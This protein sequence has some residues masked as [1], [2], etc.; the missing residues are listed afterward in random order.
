MITT[1]YQFPKQLFVCLVFILMS[2]VPLSAQNCEVVAHIVEQGSEGE[3]HS[4]VLFPAGTSTRYTTLADVEGERGFFYGDKYYITVSN[5]NETEMVFRYYNVSSWTLAATQA[6][7]NDGR[8]L[9]SAVYNP[10]DSMVYCVAQDLETRAYVWYKEQVQD[11]VMTVVVGSE[12]DLSR[13]YYAL[14]ATSDGVIYGFAAD[15]GLYQ[16]DPQ[17]GSGERLLGTGSVGKEQQ[18]SWLDESAGVLYRAVPSSIGTTFYNYNLTEKSEKFGKVYSSIKSVVALAVNDFPVE[19]SKPKAVSNLGVQWGD[20]HN[21][22][23]IVFTAP[24][25]DVNGNEMVDTLTATVWIDGLTVDTLQVLPGEECRMPYEFTDGSH[26]LSVVVGNAY[27]ESQVATCQVYAGFD[28]PQS[29]RRVNIACD[30]PCVDIWWATPQGEHGQA[31]DE[32]NLRYRVV[33]YP[34]CVLVADTPATALCDTLPLMPFMYQYGVLAYLPDYETTE[35]TSSPFYYNCI[36]Q[37]PFEFTSWNDFVFQSFVVDDTNEDGTS[38]SCFTTASGATSVRYMYSTIHD[39]DDYLYFPTM[40]LQEGIYYEATVYLRAG[41]EKY[42]EVFSMGVMSEDENGSRVELF[43][44]EVVESKA[45]RR[46]SKGFVVD[47]SG[48]YRLYIHCTSPANHYILYVDSVSVTTQGVGTQPQSVSD[49]MLQPDA[50]HPSIVTIQSVAPTM[51][52]AGTILDRLDEISLYRN[53]QLL[54]TWQNPLP[55]ETITYRDSVS[56]IDNYNYRLVATNEAGNSQPAEQSIVR[57]VADYPFAHDFMQGVGFF[58][59]IDHNHDGTTWHFYDDRFMG[60]MRYMSSA[61]VAADDWLVTPPIYLTDSIRYQVEYSCCAGHS[62]YPESLRVVMGRTPQPNAMSVVIDELYDFTFISDTVIVVPFDVS[63]SDIYY[64]AFQAVSQADSYAILMRNVKINEY[65]PMSVSSPQYTSARVWG[66]MGCIITH[67]T[68][69]SEVVIYNI[70]GKVVDRFTAS[71]D[72][73]SRNII[74]GVY[75]VYVDGVRRK[76]VVR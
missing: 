54:Y 70:D 36:M 42:S 72:V 67:V 76:V 26:T 29:V 62:H 9:L 38:W 23:V 33:R 25:D 32:E 39:A 59:T 21:S 61:S 40:H 52:E 31:I 10:V 45:S 4:M 1:I 5:S 12:M 43:S 55:G 27:G 19:Y 53:E 57:G 13:A 56:V 63:V 58:T 8:Q 14:C 35:A 44:R 74:Q 30:Y 18:S 49:M 22:G 2:I 64:L 71:R 6:R 47:N 28:L 16:I 17:D 7:V 69:G 24:L 75:I 48:E 34:D 41:S 60:C 20:N 37:P 3:K 11:D 65:N 66:G 68:P 46:Y 15:A 51:S 50:K 73:Q